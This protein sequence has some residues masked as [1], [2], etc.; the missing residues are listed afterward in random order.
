VAMLDLLAQHCVEH[1]WGKLTLTVQESHSAHLFT[2]FLQIYI[3]IKKYQL[4]LT[5]TTIQC[6]SDNTD[7]ATTDCIDHQMQAWRMTSPS[8]R[9]RPPDRLHSPV[10]SSPP[11]SPSP[12]FTSTS[13]D[14]SQQRWR[15]RFSRDV[16]GRIHHGFGTL[17]CSLDTILLF[18]SDGSI[19][20]T[21]PI[22]SQAVWL[23]GS[24]YQ[25]LGFRVLI[26]PSAH[27]HV[28]AVCHAPVPV[29]VCETIDPRTGSI[30]SINGG[31]WVQSGPARSLQEASGGFLAHHDRFPTRQPHFNPNPR[32]LC[33]IVFVSSS[34][35]PRSSSPTPASPQIWRATARG[36]GRSFA[37]VLA[38][39][40]PRMDRRFGGG[41]RS[42]P[43]RSPP[44]N[45]FGNRPRVGSDADRRDEQ[46]R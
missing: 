29:R 5:S 23:V 24:T 17:L 20:G 44:W 13:S 15:I 10:Q 12:S 22:D 9:L 46:R 1:A 4:H 36:D 33:R 34:P 28:A 41:R 6:P 43:R 39:P 21:G 35:P 2:L 7:T 19:L 26:G 18:G 38:T 40:S 25:I 30:Q 16:D 31:F 11:P 8:E 3:N 37:Q 45:Y 14:L 27:R 32:N 42:P